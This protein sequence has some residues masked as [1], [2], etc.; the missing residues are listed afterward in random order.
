M[1]PVM[2]DTK[3]DELRLSMYGLGALTP[4]W[5]T[6]DRESGYL[7]GWDREWYYHFRGCGYS[8]IEWVEIKVESSQ[9]DAAVL[10]ALH[11]IHVPGRRTDFG[12]K[13]FGYVDGPVEY[14]VS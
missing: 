13:V 4:Q 1:N 6:K 7:S 3:W 10:A 8:S 12:F 14:I 5:R 2:N 11:R 9:Q